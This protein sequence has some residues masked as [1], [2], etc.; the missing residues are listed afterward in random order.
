MKRGARQRDE[1][2]VSHSTLNY[3]DGWRLPEKV[4]SSGSFP[5]CPALTWWAPWKKKFTRIQSRRPRAAERLG[6]WRNLF[7]QLE[8]A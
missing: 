1:V 2:R 5:W 7:I 6:R 8:E 4:L 3:K